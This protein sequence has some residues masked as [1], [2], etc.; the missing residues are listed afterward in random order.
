M[1]KDNPAAGLATVRDLLRYAVSRFSEAKL[2]FGHGFPSAF[3]EAR[4]LVLH[5][6]HLPFDQMDVWLDA[7]LLPSE[8][9]HVVS[10][11][12][13]RISTRVPAAYLTHEAWLGPYRFYV[14]ERVIVP[15]S[16][17]AQL[18]MNGVEPWIQ[19]REAIKTVLDLCTGSGC[20]AIIAAQEFGNTTVDAVDISADALS[21]AQRNVDEYDLQGR[22]KLIR[23]DLFAELGR[24]KYDL[25]ISNPPY[26]SAASMRALPEEYRK[27]P[28]LA[29]AAGEDG[30]DAVR[31][32]LREAK[33][34]LT[35]GGLLLVEA[36]DCRAQLEQDYPNIPF[37]WPDTDDGDGCVFL[38]QR[39]DLP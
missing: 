20:L 32:I 6:L 36:G 16:L 37:I 25:I 39:A 35:T 34:Y 10:I 21:V 17:I 31:V 2:A 30:L 4:Y 9:A 22:V 13:Q 27:E 33:R 5:R 1:D 29:L 19:N 38:A 26:V 23:S 12:E 28:A 15:R 7:R 11:V 3:E 14:D 18:L 24:R 8:V